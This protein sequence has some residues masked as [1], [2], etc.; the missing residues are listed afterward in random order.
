MMSFKKLTGLVSALV[1]LAGFAQAQTTGEIYGKATDKSG[2]VVPGVTVTLTST[3]LLQPLVAVTSG[4][5]VYR[6]PGVPIGVYSVKFE[7]AGF[8]TVLR[9]GITI[10]I[11]QNAQINGALDVSSKQEVIEVT[12]EAPLI[13]MRSNARV[14]TFNL[15][16]LQDIPSARDP[17]VILGQSAGVVM[18]RENIGGNMSG[19]QSNFIAR[20]AA[21][22]QQKWNL[23]GVDIT[24]MSATGASP[25]YYDFDSFQEMQ[26]TTGGADVT[27]QT[28]GAGVNLVTKSGSDKFKGSGRYFFTDKKFQ[29]VNVTDALRLQGATSGN[30]IQNIKDYGLKWAVRSSRARHGS[31]APMAR[32]TS[33]PGST[34]SS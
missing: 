22:S 19:Q 31:G 13:D 29:G 3:A 11:G 16:A 32:T 7:L 2:A 8:T 1:L 4:T 12:G 6:F 17:W 34:A 15:A 5:G 27:M 30:P 14:N 20:G 26:I 25:I 24:D 23:D 33:R 10:V 28:A 9:S 21:T 18:D